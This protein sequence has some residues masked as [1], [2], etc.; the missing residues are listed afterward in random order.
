MGGVFLYIAKF[1]FLKNKT[2]TFCVIIELSRRVGYFLRKRCRWAAR[3]V[4]AL[5]TGM[6]A[7]ATGEQGNVNKVFAGSR[8]Y[9]VQGRG[10][11]Q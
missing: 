10:Y 2:N 6:E 1:Y 11:N 3:E 4:P 7:V 5:V 9:S 8:G